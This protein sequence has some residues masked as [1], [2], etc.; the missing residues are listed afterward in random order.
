MWRIK[1]ISNTIAS[2]LAYI[3]PI[4]EFQT[5]NLLLCRNRRRSLSFLIKTN[6]LILLSMVKIWRLSFQKDL[7]FIESKKATVIHSKNCIHLICCCC[8]KI[9]R[10]LTDEHKIN[11]LRTDNIFFFNFFVLTIGFYFGKN[12]Q[13]VLKFPRY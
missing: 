9:K 4:Q 11:Q 1:I 2:T 6:S 10:T 5:K 13:T 3:I 8:M 12:T 7:E